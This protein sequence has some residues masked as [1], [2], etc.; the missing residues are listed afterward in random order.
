LA[1]WLRPLYDR[2]AIIPLVEEV[3]GREV[4]EARQAV[5]EHGIKP[6]EEHP[7]IGMVFVQRELEVGQ[8]A[9]VGRLVRTIGRD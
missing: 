1:L 9:L 6:F 8:K 2:T 5:A 7:R 3:G 4:L